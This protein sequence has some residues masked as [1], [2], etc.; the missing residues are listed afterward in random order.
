[1]L[2]CPTQIVVGRQVSCDWRTVWR[3]HRSRRI[4]LPAL[5]ESWTHMRLL[6]ETETQRTLVVSRDLAK[7]SPRFF[8]PKARW[9]LQMRRGCRPSSVELF[10]TFEQRMVNTR[11]LLPQTADETVTT[12][13]GRLEMW[14]E[15]LLSVMGEQQ[16]WDTD[17][18]IAR[19]DLQS[20]YSF[21]VLPLSPSSAGSLPLLSLSLR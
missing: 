2:G 18:A 15:K 10:V 20:P 3:N 16:W 12:P 7:M 6:T 8:K 5:P 19:Q 17:Q 13:I 14:F 1:M 11:T 9:T 4:V 21:S